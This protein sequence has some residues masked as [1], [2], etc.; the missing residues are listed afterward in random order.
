MEHFVT[1]LHIKMVEKVLTFEVELPKSTLKEW[2]TVNQ[3]NIINK[4]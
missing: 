2:E 1:K 3:I 4:H